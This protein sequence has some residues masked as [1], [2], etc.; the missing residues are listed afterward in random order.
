M[1]EGLADGLARQS[2]MINRQRFSRFTSFYVSD[3]RILIVFE[4][5]RS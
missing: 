1:K 4:L 5:K 3:F 2:L